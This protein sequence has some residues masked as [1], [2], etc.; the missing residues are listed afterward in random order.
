MYYCNPSGLDEL[1]NALIVMK[2]MNSLRF[3]IH[4]LLLTRMT[5]SERKTYLSFQQSRTRPQCN[6]FELL[7][8]VAQIYVVLRNRERDHKKN[9]LGALLNPAD[10]QIIASTHHFSL[11]DSTY[12][13]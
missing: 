2:A 12:Y 10:F 11:A 7:R 3:S 1:S 9:L 13:M 4:H 8:T 5:W 6:Y